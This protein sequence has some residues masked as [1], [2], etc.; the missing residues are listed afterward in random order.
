MTAT[1]IEVPHDG[2]DRIVVLHSPQ[3]GPLD[4][5]HLVDLPCRLLAVALTREMADSVTQAAPSVLVVDHSLGDFN[6]ERVVRELTQLSTA[7]IVVLAGEPDADD[8]WR[9]SL[10]D[11]GAHVVLAAE[12]RPSLL[13]AQLRAML[14]LAPRTPAGP[15]L[16]VVGDVTIDVGAHRLL[17]EDHEVGCSP[18]LFSLLVALA[19]SPNRVL[20]RETLLGRVWG[21]SPTSSNL[22][23]VRIAASQLRRLLGAGPR[24]PRIETVARVGY[25]LAVD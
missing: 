12:T 6:V 24:R 3:A 11:D 14:R 25:C 21:V 7:P 2:G 13:I 9:I 8:S 23:R 1:P 16:L 5:D 10:L 17:I 19:T 18:V 15:E 22:R 20:P 4:L